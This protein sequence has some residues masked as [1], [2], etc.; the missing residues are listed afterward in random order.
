MLKQLIHWLAGIPNHQPPTPPLPVVRL[1]LEPHAADGSPDIARLPR[2]QR[3][4]MEQRVLARQFPSFRWQQDGQRASVEGPIRTSAGQS[5]EVRI[6]VPAAFPY[7]HACA[8]ILSP[9]SGRE[10]SLTETS[11]AM[12]TLS[13]DSDGN[14]Q[15]CLYNDRNWNPALTLQHVLIKAAL[16]LEAFEQHG[17]TGRP[18]S[19]FLASVR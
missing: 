2:A 19:D 5:Y 3:L 14:P 11:H 6:L 17:R 16:W 1:A 4:F 7:S 9:I 8:F 18:I 12:H 10:C 15:I 13:P